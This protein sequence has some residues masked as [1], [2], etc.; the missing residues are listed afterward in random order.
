MLNVSAKN[1][2]F[3]EEFPSTYEAMSSTLAQALNA[4]ITRKWIGPE[5]EFYARLCL[6]EALVNAI[7]HGNCG[8]RERRVGLEMAEDGDTCVI[9]VWDEGQGFCCDGIRVPD[10]THKGGRGLCLIKH[11]MDRI[12]FDPVSRR[13]EM[14][15][16]RNSLSKG[17]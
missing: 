6:E 13:F 1:V 16:R 15:F 8:D 14:A 5:Q 12:E 9:A 2:F 3:K 10:C 7:E 17:A 11:F 4:L